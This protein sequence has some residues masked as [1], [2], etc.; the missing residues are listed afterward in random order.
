MTRNEELYRAAHQAFNRRDWEAGTRDFRNDAVYHDQARGT[1][2]KGPQEFKQFMQA[3]VSTFSNAE[4]ASPTYYS[5]GDIVISQFTGRG[6][7]DGSLGSFAPTGKK[8]NLPFCEIMRFDA[9]G[10]IVEGWIYYDQ[11]SLLS[12]LG[13]AP[14]R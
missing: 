7:N 1:T 9:S 10:K 2:F 14:V 6:T 13:H 3:W 12:Q 5:V 4:V 8:L 11:L